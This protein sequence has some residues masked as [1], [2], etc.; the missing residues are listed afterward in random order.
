GR[1]L[2]EIPGIT[3]WAL[4]G[5]LDLR[6]SGRLLQ[7]EAGKSILNSF[8]RLSSPVQAFVEDACEVGPSHKVRCDELREAWK[9][10]CELNGPEP[11][12]DAGFSVK[13]RAA[14]SEVERVRIGRDAQGKQQYFYE[15][16]RLTPAA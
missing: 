9:V 3:N 14:V 4:N 6:R 11:G 12:S 15:G 8:A 10:W 7:P 5:L 16:L 13:L 2:A 1:L